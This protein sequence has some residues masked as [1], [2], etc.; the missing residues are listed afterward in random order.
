LSRAG[1][2]ALGGAGAAGLSSHAQAATAPGAPT[3]RLAI[4]TEARDG[5][6][7][8]D[9]KRRW[10]ALEGFPAGWQALVGDEVAVAPS[11]V[12]TG[13]SAHPIC[14]WETHDVAPA[15]LAPASRISG[16]DG[17]QVVGATIL[18]GP[19]AERLQSRDRTSRT[20]LVAVTNNASK[21]GAKRVIA[22]REA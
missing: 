22:V 12:A 13:L 8:V 4:V 16:A 15:N 7:R 11:L 17:P 5:A 19:L 10:L 6:V 9:G 1:L 3:W 14:T 21:T 2:V 20:L 18:E